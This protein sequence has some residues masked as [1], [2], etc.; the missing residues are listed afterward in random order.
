MQPTSEAVASHAPSR[1]TRLLDRLQKVSRER[2]LN[3][4]TQAA[5]LRWIRRF[6]LFHGKRHP[7]DMGP[8]E[9]ALFLSVVASEGGAGPSTRSQAFTALQFLFQGMLGRDLGPLHALPQP[10]ERPSPPVGCD[11]RTAVRARL[12]N[13]RRRPM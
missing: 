13:L 12:A 7:D 4:R 5:Y 11:S 2:G 9:V 10:P 6:I 1:P 3:R 8:A